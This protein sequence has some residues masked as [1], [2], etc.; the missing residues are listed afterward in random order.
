M[1]KFIF[2]TILCFSV[3]SGFAQKIATPVKP[4]KPSPVQTPLLLT[5]ISDAEWKNLTDSLKTELWEK[6]ALL[7]AEYSAKIKVD[8]EKKQL[9]QLRYFYLYALA[10]KIL[11]LS[12]AN[13]TPEETAAWQELDK[14]VGDFTGKEFVLPPRR[15][16]PECKQ[17]LNYICAVRDNDRALRVTATN[18]AGTEIHSFDYVLFDDKNSLDRLPE[19]N[20][21]LGGILKRAEFNQDLSK[22]WVMRLFFAKGFVS[23]AAAD[24]K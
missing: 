7:A 5:K 3:S 24:G 15:F 19:T 23:F 22:R 12:T 6:S 8:N 10:G 16:L 2:F 14:A 9:A 11:A 1:K 4:I 17:V 13:K 20:I 21:F 18:A